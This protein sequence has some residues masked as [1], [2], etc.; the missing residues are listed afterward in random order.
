[1]GRTWALPSLSALP[2]M[3][4]MS[5]R[6]ACFFFSIGSIN[7]VFCK[8]CKSGSSHDIYILVTS[9]SLMIFDACLAIFPVASRLLSS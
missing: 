6:P 7:A 3:L 2:K 4:Q 8:D 1:M 5:R 9:L